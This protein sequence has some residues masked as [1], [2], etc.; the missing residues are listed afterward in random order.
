[1]AGGGKLEAGDHAQGGGFAAAAGAKQAEEFPLLDF[2]IKMVD[3][4]YLLK[5]FAEIFENDF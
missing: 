4:D 2:E 5:F 1:L 3:R